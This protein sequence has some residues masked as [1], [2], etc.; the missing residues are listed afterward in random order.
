MFW[1]ISC[2]NSIEL[3]KDFYIQKRDAEDRYYEAIDQQNSKKLPYA[4]LLGKNKK[5]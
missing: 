1:F 5:K 4:V 2:R 3:K